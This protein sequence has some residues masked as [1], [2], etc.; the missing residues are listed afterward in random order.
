MNLMLTQ[1]NALRIPLADESV[2]CVVCSPPYWGLRDYGIGDQLGLEP[3]PEQ[4]VANMAA[5]F[6]EVRRVLRADGT[7]WLNMGDSYARNPGRGVKFEGPSNIIPQM[8]I[9]KL[10]GPEVP[11]GLKEKDLCGIPWRVAFALQAD[12]WWLRSDIIWSK[13]NPMPESVTDR[14]TKA[15]EYLFLLTKSARYY[16]DADAV[17]EEAL[18]GDHP[19]NNNREWH[20]RGSM[21]RAHGADELGKNSGR[22]RR[23]VW[24]IATAPYSG[25]HFATYPPA[26]VEP[27]IKAGTS[28][29]GVCPECGAPWER[30]VEKNRMSRPELPKDDPRYRPGRYIGKLTPIK[31]EMGDA[32]YT[33][34][35]TLGWRPTCEHYPQVEDWCEYPDQKKMSDEEYALVCDPIR[36]WRDEL[37]EL[38]EPY[39]S[40]PCIVFDPFA[41]SGT[42]LQVARALSR[43][44]IGLDL[45]LEYLHLAR[46]R[47]SLDA[48]EAWGKAKKDGKAVTDL[49]MFGGQDES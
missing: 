14:P 47:L 27:C 10:S 32:G 12:G 25:A 49:P 11:N 33:E 20:D 13:P 37:V 29:R 39:E 5:V 43:N 36:Q 40:V 28:E 9:D 44:G 21:K 26:L 34:T 48:L 6:R 23:T 16:Y 22:N 3:T 2:H 18:V 30:V 42:T 24:H 4:Y 41:G 15:H 46:Q 31:G 45:S 1:G 35:T 7:V 17:R 19:R 8:N 38:W